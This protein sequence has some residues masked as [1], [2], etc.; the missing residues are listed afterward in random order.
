MPF[1]RTVATASPSP[2]PALSKTVDHLIH[3]AEQVARRVFGPVRQ[4]E[5]QMVRIGLCQCPEAEVGHRAPPIVASA[6]TSRAGPRDGST[7]GPA[8]GG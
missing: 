2:T 1:G 6:L 8:S 7:P 3:P 4:T 5:C